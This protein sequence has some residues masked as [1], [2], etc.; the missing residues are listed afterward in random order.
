MGTRNS[1]VLELEIRWVGE[2]WLLAPLEVQR[3]ETILVFLGFTE[4]KTISKS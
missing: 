3:F 1:R 4:V 2:A